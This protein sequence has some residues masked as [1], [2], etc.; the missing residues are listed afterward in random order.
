MAVGDKV[1]DKLKVMV[2]EELLVEEALGDTELDMVIDAEAVS[3]PVNDWL[4]ETV[5]VYV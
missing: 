1:G 3:W 5:S 2:V 4:R